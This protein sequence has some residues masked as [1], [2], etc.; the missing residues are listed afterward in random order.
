MHE[1]KPHTGS[2]FSIAPGPSCACGSRQPTRKTH[3]PPLVAARGSLLLRHCPELLFCMRTPGRLWQ[4]TEAQ[5]ATVSG[6]PGDSREAKVTA[7]T[8]SSLCAAGVPMAAGLPGLSS[9]AQ[10]QQLCPF[11]VLGDCSGSPSCHCARSDFPEQGWLLEGCQG[12]RVHA[13]I[14]TP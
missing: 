8:G 7:S 11:M 9:A 10:A 6:F 14:Q 12:L 3:S 5:R 1:G 13:C 4:L 2:H